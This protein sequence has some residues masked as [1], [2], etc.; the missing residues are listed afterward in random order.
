MTAKPFEQFQ[1]ILNDLDAKKYQGAFR[2]AWNMDYPDM[3]N[4][5]RP[6]F[7]KEAITNGSNYSGYV[8]EDFE[9]LLVKGDQAATHE[10]AVKQ[11]QQAD[12][13]LL[14]DLPYI[15][16]YFYTLNTGFSDKI[17][18][19]KIAGHNILWDSVKLS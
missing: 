4:Y 8:N 5:L 18:S 19:M 9:K 15:P 11:Y 3:E 6:I 13:V 17:K 14:K 7:S 1:T 10:D 2:M 12:D 16:L